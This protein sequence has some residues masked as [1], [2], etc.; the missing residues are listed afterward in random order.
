MQALVLRRRNPSPLP[1]HASARVSAVARL[2]AEA[3]LIRRH[4]AEF[5]ALAHDLGHIGAVQAIVQARWDEYVEVYRSGL[6]HG[7]GARR[8]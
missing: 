5:A 3:T 8:A 4:P 2:D 1:R 7:R 6:G